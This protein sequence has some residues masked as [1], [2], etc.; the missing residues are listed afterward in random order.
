[1]GNKLKIDFRQELFWD[2]DPKKIDPDKNARYVIERILDF[3]HDNE[4]RWMWHYYD[5]SLIASIINESRVL[6]NE[7]RPL[8]SALLQIT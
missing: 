3:G 8:W 4:A 2:V 1:M 7:T 5:H 6:R